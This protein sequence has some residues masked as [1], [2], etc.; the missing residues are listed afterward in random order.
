MRVIQEA[1]GNRAGYRAMQ[2][3]PSSETELLQGSFRRFYQRHAR[4]CRLFHHK[5]RE[6]SFVPILMGCR[7]ANLLFMVNYAHAERTKIVPTNRLA[8]DSL[9]PSNKS[10]FRLE[11]DPE[12]L[13][14][15]VFH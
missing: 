3:R 5:K 7:E 11:V 10:F 8:S 4:L 14:E 13:P 6:G 9:G 15:A 12:H 2:E 1:G